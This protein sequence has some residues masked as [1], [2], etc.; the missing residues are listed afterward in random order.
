MRGRDRIESAAGRLADARRNGRE[1]VG[2][3]PALMQSD[4]ISGKQTNTGSFIRRN[5]AFFFYISK[6][7]A[8]LSVCVFKVLPRLFF[9]FRGTLIQH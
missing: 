1:H 6:V 3:L 7:A 5:V 9:F 4:A 8:F 2:F